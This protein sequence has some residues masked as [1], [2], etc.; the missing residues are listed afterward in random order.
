MPIL[1]QVFFQVVFQV[2]LVFLCVFVQ[3]VE[4]ANAQQDQSSE[5]AEEAPAKSPFLSGVRQI[6]F[7]GLRAGEG[8]FGTGAD[9]GTEMVFQSERRGDNPFFQIYTLDFETGDTAP[10]SPG[11]GKTTCGWLHPDGNRVLFA[12]TQFDP[13]AK[14]KQLD[15][16]EFRESGQTRL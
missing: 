5:T 7:E 12:S 13:D 11:H 14:Q 15:E 9:N 8:Y 6:T 4:P 2:L 3:P 16:L 1:P 10:V